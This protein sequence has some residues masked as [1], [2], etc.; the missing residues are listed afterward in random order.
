MRRGHRGHALLAVGRL[1]IGEQE[2]PRLAAA[3]ADAAAELVELR[4]PEAVGVLDDHHG[5]V[6]HVDADLD[7]G[8]RD[9]HVDLAA[10]GTRPSP[11]PS[12][13]TS[14]ARAA[15]PSRRPASSSCCSRSYSSVAALRL[16]L[17]LVLDERAD[18]VR[19]VP[20]LDLV[21]EA[22]PTP[23]PGRAGSD[24]R[25]SVVIGVRPGGISRSS[26]LSRSPYTSIAAVRGIGVAVITSTSGSS[27]LPPEQRAL[28]DTEPVLLV[29]HR[30]AEVAELGVAVEQRVRADEDVDLAVLHRGR[31]PSAFGGGRA[32]GEQLDAHGPVAEQRAVGR[33]G[34][35]GEQR[36][37][38]EVVLFGEHLGRRHERALVPALHA[39]EQRGERDHGLARP[40]VALQQPV[41]RRVARHVARRSRRS[42]AAGRR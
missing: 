2:A 26:D 17:A 35:T 14:S 24:R 30:D 3:A 10:A 16:D 22:R 15:D 31:Q 25:P 18:D 4:E 21:A 39:D 1:R 11:L 36:G 29:D 8:R 19:L 33:D 5:R 9:E 13:S 12:P 40:D 20:G 34:E 32:V 41:H 23:L 28:L 6:R 27:P 7:H 42:C 38:R 37:R